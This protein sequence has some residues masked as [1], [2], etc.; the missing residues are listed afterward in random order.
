MIEITHA[1]ASPEYKNTH[2][3]VV[4]HG[5]DDMPYVSYGLASALDYAATEVDRIA[6][7]TH[8]EALACHEN[9]EWEDASNAFVRSEAQANLAANLT[10][11]VRNAQSHTP[12]DR[13]PH[14][15]Q[16]AVM[17]PLWRAAV[18]HLFNDPN[19][20]WPD[21]FAFY[22]CPNAECSPM[23]WV[24]RHGGDFVSPVEGGRWDRDEYSSALIALGYAMREWADNDSD[25]ATVESILADHRTDPPVNV[26]IHAEDGATYWWTLALEPSED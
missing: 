12:D 13:A 25:D 2:W 10:A 6:D 26:R 19:T 8:D 11:L 5:E 17:G 22:S 18:A 9:G 20:E 7:S 21:G 15:R 24:I 23:D 14:Y 1:M 3:H 16:E 4:R